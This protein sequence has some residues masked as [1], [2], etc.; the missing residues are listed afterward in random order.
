MTGSTSDA[1][2]DQLVKAGWLAIGLSQRDLADVLDAVL[3]QPAA[4]GDEFD[5]VGA[6]RL[7]E[8]AEALDI[9]LDL[10]RVSANGMELTAG[11][12]AP[13]ELS[14]SLRSLLELRLLRAFCQLEDRRTK[15]MLVHLAE[16]IAKRQTDRTG[17]AS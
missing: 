4:S 7:M 12:T 14:G 13:S 11:G 2:I 8:V 15:L 16:Q 17:E 3:S 9:S 1:K 10:R 5:R 6:E